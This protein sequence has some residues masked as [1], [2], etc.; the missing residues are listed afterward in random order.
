[1]PP[2]WW[3]HGARNGTE[4]PFASESRQLLRRLPGSRGFVVY[5]RPAP[6]DRRGEDFDATGRV[7]LPLLQELGIPRDAD[8]YLC[9]PT[10]FLEDLSAGLVASGFCPERVHSEIFGPGKSITPGVVGAQS[11]SPHPPSGPPGAGPRVSFARSGL[12]VR[13]DPAYR[14]L[15]ELA[16]ACDVPVRWSCR[17]GVCHTCE[18]GL[19]SGCVDYFQEPI[20]PPAR[21]NVL[22]CCATA[23]GDLDLDL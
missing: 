11:R 12:T 18:T 1:P 13:W 4:H 2:V 7:A 9:G 16:E 6:T 19:I 23:S 8:L 21:G 5:S 3:I 15:L 10:A 14:S 20:A 17:T 22:T